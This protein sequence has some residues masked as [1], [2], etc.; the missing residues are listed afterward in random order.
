ME[1]GTQLPFQIRKI[2]HIRNEQCRKKIRWQV[3]WTS[4]LEIF[5]AAGEGSRPSPSSQG[6]LDFPLLRCT[7]SSNAS[8]ALRWAGCIKSRGVSS[9]DCATSSLIDAKQRA[10]SLVLSGSGDMCVPREMSKKFRDL[11]LRHLTRMTL[12]VEQDKAANPLGI[13]LFGA[14]T[15]MFSANRVPD[16]IEQLRLVRLGSSR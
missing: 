16:L 1:S 15:K 8:R 12:V 4:S 13:T 14:N 6:N 5:F 10:Q 11:R 2:F 7:A 9:A 3:L